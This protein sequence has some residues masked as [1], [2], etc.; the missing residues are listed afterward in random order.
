MADISSPRPH[1]ILNIFISLDHAE[2][3]QL[4]SSTAEEFNVSVNRYLA[5]N[6]DFFYEAEFYIFCPKTVSITSFN[7]Q[8][9]GFNVPLGAQMF[10]DTNQLFFSK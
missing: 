9:F 1:Y 3:L 4:Y 10:Y 2:L 8:P 6:N 5:G 7:E